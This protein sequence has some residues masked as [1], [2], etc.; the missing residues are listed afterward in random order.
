MEY[1]LLKNHTNLKNRMAVLRNRRPSSR[2]HPGC[3]DPLLKFS[4]RRV[5]PPPDTQDLAGVDGG[6]AREAFRDHLEDQPPRYQIDP[7]LDRRLRYLYG[8]CGS[9]RDRDVCDF[10]DQFAIVTTF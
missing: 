3:T 5:D 10:R 8:I 9:R 7:L 1:M 4:T 2:M 6:E